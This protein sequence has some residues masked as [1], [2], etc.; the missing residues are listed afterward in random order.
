MLPRAD[1]F[2]FLADK[3]TGLCGGGLSFA[4]IAA[5]S[6]DGLFLGMID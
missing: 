2:D 6:F 1:F 5:R 3:F 4:L